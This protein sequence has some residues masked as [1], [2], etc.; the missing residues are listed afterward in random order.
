MAR[1]RDTES[2][3]AGGAER[4]DGSGTSHGHGHGTG[5]GTGTGSGTGTGTEFPPFKMRVLAPDMKYYDLQSDLLRAEFEAT[6]VD[7]LTTDLVEMGVHMSHMKED[8]GSGGLL[9]TFL[10]NVAAFYPKDEP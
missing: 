1:E 2:G 8:A 10:V 3:T 9:G 5:T 4:G 7:Q 6:N